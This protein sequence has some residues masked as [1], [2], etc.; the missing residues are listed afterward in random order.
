MA[1][2]HEYLDYLNDKVDIAPT[3]SQEELQAAELLEGIMADHEL[4][5]DLQDFEMPGGG[6]LPYR[7]MWIVLFVAVVLSGI[8]GTPVSIVGIVLV[9][10]LAVLFG[11]K[12]F[13][14]RNLLGSLGPT[15]RSQ[16][17]IGVHRATGPLVTKGN[18]PIVIVAHYNTPRENFMY[19]RSLSRLL[20]V[21]SRMSV[22]LTEIC[23][24]MGILQIMLF[25]P[26]VLRHVFWFVGI[27]CAIPL[28]LLGVAAVYERFAPC[29]GGASDNKAAVAAM[30]GVLDKVRPAEDEATGYVSGRP[31]TP[32]GALDEDDEDWADEM[33]SAEDGEWDEEPLDDDS[34]GDGSFGDETPYEDDPHVAASV[35]AVPRATARPKDDGVK[36]EPA[37]PNLMLRETETLEDVEGVRHGAEALVRLGVIPASAEIFY[38]GP[39]VVVRRKR[40]YVP[41]ANLPKRPPEPEPEPVQADEKAA[42]RDAES[43]IPDWLSSPRKDETS[44]LAQDLPEV[45]ETA[46]LEPARANDVD[47]ADGTEVLERVGE[48]THVVDEADAEAAEE[49][50][51]IAEDTTILSRSDVR[52]AEERGHEEGKES[53][54]AGEGDAYEGDESEYDEEG[55]ADDAAYEEIDDEDDEA[56][57]EEDDDQYDDDAYADGDEYDETY[58][59]EYEDEYDD[60]Y[61]EGYEVYEGGEEYADEAVG[62]PH[63]LYFEQEYPED[64]PEEPLDAEFEI[65]N[66][67]FYEPETSYENGGILG[68]IRGLFSRRGSDFETGH[69]GPIPQIDESYD[70]YDEEEPVS[71]GEEYYEEGPVYD[72]APAEGGVGDDGVEEY[73]GE[74]VTDEYEY[75]QGPVQQIDTSRVSDEEVDAVFGEIAAANPP[76]AYEA[77]DY[78]SVDEVPVEA[79][80]DIDGDAGYGE[81]P[82]LDLPDDERQ[83]SR[84]AVQAPV[85]DEAA[86][87]VAI[88]AAEEIA[89]AGAEEGAGVAAEEAPSTVAEPVV[90]PAAEP[91]LAAEPAAVEDETPHVTSEPVVV[92]QEKPAAEGAAGTDVAPAEGFPAAGGAEDV[93]AVAVESES[94]TEE[95]LVAEGVPVDELGPEPAAGYQDT[96]EVGAYPE[97][98]FEGEAVL[99]GQQP[100][101]Q[102]PVY[103]EEQVYEQGAPYDSTYDQEAFDQF[104]E[105][106]PAMGDEA[107]TQGSYQEEYHIY[108]EVAD[109]EQIVYLEVEDFPDDEYGYGDSAGT[110]PEQRAFYEPL[111]DY[112]DVPYES[113]AAQDAGEFGGTDD[114][115]NG[116]EP[117]AE[118]AY[119]DALSSAEEPYQTDGIRVDDELDRSLPDI[120]VPERRVPEVGEATYGEGVADGYD[121]E[122]ALADTGHLE[123][124]SAEVAGEGP[125]EDT[126][127][128]ESVLVKS[129]PAEQIE[130]GPVGDDADQVAE[131][132]AQR[133]I[134][135][136]RFFASRREGQTVGAAPMVESPVTQASTSQAPVDEA[137]AQPQPADEDWESAI[138]EDEINLVDPS[139]EATGKLKRITSSQIDTSKDGQ[140][141]S[142]AHDAY[143]S[144]AT[145]GEPQPEAATPEIVPDDQ[146]DYGYEGA[147][148]PTPTSDAYEVEGYGAFEGPYEDQTFDGET[149]FEDYGADDAGYAYD[150]SSPQGVDHELMQERTKRVG[151]SFY[152]LYYDDEDEVMDAEFEVIDGDEDLVAGKT[153]IFG[154]GELT[155][156]SGEDVG[157]DEDYEQAGDGYYEQEPRALGSDGA[158]GQGAYEE[159]PVPEGA[160]YD[161]GYD[162]ALDEP[163]ETETADQQQEDLSEPYDDMSET[164]KLSRLRFSRELNDIDE[165]EYE[166][167]DSSGLDVMAD[168]G[169]LDATDPNALSAGERPPAPDDPNWGVSE[170]EPPQNQGMHRS[171][172]YDLPNPTE[173][174]Y[175]SLDADYTPHSYSKVE[176]MPQQAQDSYADEVAYEQGLDGA[177]DTPRTVNAAPP[178]AKE[179][180]GASGEGRPDGDSL[181]VTADE[182]LGSESAVPREGFDASAREESSVPTPVRIGSDAPR[183]ETRVPTR[184]VGRPRGTEGGDVTTSEVPKEHRGHGLFDRFR[185]HEKQEEVQE[186]SLSDWLGVDSDY[187]AKKDG[188]EIGSWDNFLDDERQQGDRHPDDGSEGTETGPSRRGT[189]W[190]GGAAWRIGLREPEGDAMAGSGGDANDELRDAILAMG[191]DELISHDIWFVAVGASDRDHIGMK[192]FLQD[193]R[194]QIRGAFLINLDCVGSGELTALTSEGLIKPRKADRRMVRNLQ[195]IANDLH[196]KLHTRAAT[197]RETDATPA[198]RKSVRSVTLTGLNGHGVPDLSRTPD[199]EVENVRP[200]QVAGIAR[201][202]T[203]FIRQA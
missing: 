10:I 103:Q 4:E 54:D 33:V 170:Y 12:Y 17:V 55:H 172:L 167:K 66:R 176:A 11:L 60:E 121:D 67:T 125:L 115:F 13:A 119:P 105:Q 31:S 143:E 19:G 96:L 97:A 78:P 111:A 153:Q 23:C 203:E 134:G 24:A 186:E 124:L 63:N 21:L 120:S 102:Q 123:P 8:A 71:E 68:K 86:D 81:M 173:D 130:Q 178:A 201:L 196:M 95:A 126:G 135:I 179:N 74:I 192:K 3:N 158:Y 137:E 87:A 53:L 149:P 38:E 57:A 195:H 184:V 148:E 84:E 99:E 75:Y 118:A 128:V 26:L 52:S 18:R 88:G 77:P 171:V 85:D 166:G 177:D 34:F 5:V 152:Y 73:V 157:F 80:D 131:K 15:V 150:A 25:L 16:N 156:Q 182:S 136:D 22:L 7:I 101:E 147:V 164:G 168:D 133:L 129:V 104:F 159:S 93:D 138:F 187:D 189:S 28:C 193:Y 109:P 59:D 64:E 32:R 162:D 190:K 79:Y 132:P 90:E 140:P 141:L 155:D 200:K 46:V 107:S 163:M 112:G 198:M 83:P 160:A 145:S 202:I 1:S 39:R 144:Q 6:E 62:Y 174:Y 36:M 45:E 37:G 70:Y 139:L 127:H 185:R 51:D 48:D 76:I 142:A 169:S 175:R 199:D 106:P 56:Y 110:A 154:V 43:E 40:V 114:T 47:D 116:Q 117:Y 151:G 44:R 35:R 191:D 14:G 58:S 89:S 100:Y 194:S 49:R 94:F 98:G 72:E 2:T 183:I 161:A 20:P 29:T 65:D 113:Y 69:T 42:A 146:G 92:E 108:Q 188:R 61:A 30:L 197:W 165:V 50:D 91:E 27:V 181:E 41:G 180:R 9:A 122:A 82:P